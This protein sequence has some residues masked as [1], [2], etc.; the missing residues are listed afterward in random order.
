M[1]NVCLVGR[2]T[3]DPELRY[4]TSGMAVVR[5]TLAVD[6]RMSKEKRMEAEAKNQPTADFISCTAWNKTA[7][8]I[9]NYVQKGSR[10]GVEGRIQTG[11]YEKDGQRVYTTDVIVNSMEF[12]DPASQSGGMRQNQGGQNFGNQSGPVNSAY[13]NNFSQNQNQNNFGGNNSQQDD[14]DGFFPIDNDDIPF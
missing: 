13:N 8:L 3:R 7:E 10:L 14:I 5:F 1:N 11:S 6:R 4:T 12:L 9:A 2:L